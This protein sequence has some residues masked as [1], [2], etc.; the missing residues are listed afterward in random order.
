MRRMLSAELINVCN[1]TSAKATLES[2]IL[3]LIMFYS[4]LE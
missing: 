3:D 4:R 1:V 2:L